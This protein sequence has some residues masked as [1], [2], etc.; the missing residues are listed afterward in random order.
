MIDQILRDDDDVQIDVLLCKRS[1]DHGNHRGQICLPGGKSE[2]HESDY[3]TV[4]REIKEET[5]Y[6]MEQ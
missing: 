3:Q 6:D 2:D 5:G 1:N 4:I